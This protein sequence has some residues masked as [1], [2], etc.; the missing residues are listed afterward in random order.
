MA[1]LGW[2]QGQVYSTAAVPGQAQVNSH[3]EITSLFYSFIQNYRLNNNFIY[4]DQLQ[5]NVLTKQYFIEVD[6]LDLIGY[7]ADL[8]NRLKNS[9]ADYLP[10]FENAVKESAK[11]ILYANPN[12]NVHVPDCQ[13][14]LKSNENVVQI[15]DLNSD[16]IGK[17]VR[18]PG[19]V[20]GASTLSSRAT[21]VT[22]MCRSCMT[23]KIMPIQGGFS[24]I[25]LPRNCDSTSADGGKNNCP[26]DPFVIVHDKCRFVDSQVIKLQEA[27]DTVPVGDLPRHTILNAD[28][29]LTNRVVPGMRAVIMGIYSIYQNKSAK[30]PGTAAVRTPYIRV[31]GLDIDQHN[32]GRG[33]PHFTDAEE[34]EYIRMSRQPDLYE[35]LASSLA[36]SIFGNEDI[37]K[38]IIC[39]LFG[40]SKK[41]LPDGMRLRGDIS[42]LLL[43][44]PG[45]AKSQLLK[46][47]EKVAPIA[48]YTSGKGSSAAGLTASVIRDPST[49]DFYLE[50]GAMV[51]A[52][53]GVVCIDEFDKMR[54]E[55]RVAIHEAMEQQTISIAKAGITTILNSRTSVLAA[56][57]PIF[58]RYDDMKSAGENIDF[59]TTILSRFDMIFVVKDEHNENRDVA[60]IDEKEETGHVL[61]VHMNKQTQDAVMG[62]IGL[63]K[64]KAYVNY[65]KAKCAPR[66]TP[67]AAEKLSSHFVSIRKELKET[68]RETQIRSTIPITIRQLEAI[69]RISESLAKMT[70]S[71]YATE[72][73]VDEALRLFKYSTMDA[74]QS[75]GA[76]GMTRED[77]MQEVAL[78]EAEVLKRLPVGSQIRVAAI[79]GD[80]LQRG[81]SE[82]AIMRALTIL[83]RREVL[84]VR[85]QGK[86][87]LRQGV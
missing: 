58:G 56:A 33:K 30:T 68:E 55:D 25:T 49:R 83:Q 57:N 42:V 15:R 80:L 21:E 6:M 70:L 75:G 1:A 13:V 24:A 64:M 32:S 28:R 43:G 45:T 19:I 65:C 4:R 12:N 2:D 16:Y 74:V 51:L 61:N 29:W 36:P 8:A 14:L 31:V 66:L 76:D 37:K 72:K 3:S 48:V 20:I 34:E 52:D 77:V 53:G 79:K 9:P 26:M 86:I 23:T 39:L 81:Y 38:S 11:R 78:I 87:V 82:A 73:H 7:N 40:G 50:G 62:E 5:E 27:P 17:L 46:F 47:T 60:S 69:V 71:P 22:V 85:G 10:L 67:Q 41:I 35:T 63:E 18:I 44:D 84:L 54:D 59:Q